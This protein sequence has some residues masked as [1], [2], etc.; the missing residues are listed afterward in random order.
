LKNTES[1]DVYLV[2]NDVDMSKNLTIK[3]EMIIICLLMLDK[4]AAK[5]WR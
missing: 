4:A 3:R 1:D 2:L 5:L